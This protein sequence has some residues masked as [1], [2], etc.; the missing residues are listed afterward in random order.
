[1]ADDVP[2]E[3]AAARAKLQAKFESRIGGK[4]TVRRKVKA[5]NTGVVVNEDKK[6]QGSF[7]KMGLNQIPGIEEV[8]MFTDHAD[9]GGPQVI[10]FKEPKVHASLQANTYAISGT[11]EHK[12]LQEMLPKV[13]PQL[14]SENLMSIRKVMETAAGKSGV[15]PDQDADIPEIEGDFEEVSKDLEVD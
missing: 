11:A 2:A 9:D 1:M 8:N 3:I 5:K 6:L 7:K 12:T 10:H 14:G 15:T 4:G 13:I